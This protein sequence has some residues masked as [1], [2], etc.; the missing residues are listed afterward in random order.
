[1]NERIYISSKMYWAPEWRELRHAGWPIISTW[2]DEAGVG[3][4]ASFSDLWNR[5]INEAS[6]ATGLI[7]VGMQGDTLKGALIEV[8]AALAANIPVAM[9]MIGGAEPPWGMYTAKAHPLVIG[10]YSN[11][12][13]AR[14]A[15]QKTHVG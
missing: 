13:E 3:E 14:S 8:G 5:C 12:Y 2:I 9:V 7:L 15:L 11:V 4:T 10:Q 6:S 1:M